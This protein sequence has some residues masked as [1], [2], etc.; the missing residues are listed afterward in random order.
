M[1][2]IRILPDALAS[3]VAAGEVVERPAALVRELVENS[4]DAGARH[5]EVHAQRGGIAMIRIVDDGSGMDREDAMLCLE[6][7]ATSKIRTK[8]DLGA[9]HTFGFRGEAL[10]SIAS[11]SR[12]RLATREKTAL[13][14][15]EIEVNGGK[16]VAVRDHG[17]APGTVVEARSLFFNVPARRK[18]LR[19]ENTEFAHVEQQLRLHAIA[20]PQVAFTLTHN[21]DLV[22]H[23]PATRDMLERIRG[24]VG[25]ELASRLLKVEETTLHGVTISGY[26]GG[27][28]MSRSNRQMQTTYLNGRP[29]ESASIS[30]GLREGYHTALMKGQHPVT[31]LFI[32][33]DAQ[34]FDVNVHPAKK[35]VRFHDG[36]S[37]REAIA[38]CVSRTLEKAAKLPT[39]HAPARPAPIPHAAGSTPTLPSSRQEQ[40]DMPVAASSAPL[41]NIEPARPQVPASTPTSV[42][43]HRVADV[44]ARIAAA[45]TP[46]APPLPAETAATEEEKAEEPQ[47]PQIAS[48]EEETEEHPQEAVVDTKAPEA[49][50]FRII[51]V[52]QKLYVLMESKEGLVLMD[53]HAAHERV[54]FE[55]FRRAIES[56]GVP[57]QRL[58]MPI[59]LQTTPRDADLLKQNLTS[60]NR[61]GI[62][63]EPFGPNIF[64]VETLP[65][66]LKTD[67]P[68]AWLDQVIEEL[69][70]LSSKSSSLRLSEDAIA[71]I[72]CR[73]SVKSNDVL[74]IPEL[75]ALLKD[76]FACEMP[77]CCPHGRP[78]LVQISTSE[79]ERKFGRRAPG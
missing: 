18:F 34:A 59:T 69:S 57:C 60:L 9:I 55:K 56:G 68:S 45:R 63:I 73:A 79:L 7:H 77:Y 53:Q 67:D 38:R 26:I 5:I 71:T 42:V 48:P 6:R 10:P 11:V 8:E 37:V 54:N 33:M 23:L 61:L 46:A 40:F 28:G 32:Q 13:V 72:A 1:A 50:D 62:E 21:G 75:Q 3:Q 70:S 43:S 65:S 64:K 44:L 52:L 51:G 36:N 41:R 47:Q 74:S 29:I 4:L 25:D 20:N 49:P 16:M 19:T 66:F 39:G 22:L 27:P 76:L 14:G 12:F 78:T 24:L 58:L 17:G 2:K 30:Y 31:F 35:E 15:T